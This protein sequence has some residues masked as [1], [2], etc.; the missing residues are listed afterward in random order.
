MIQW[1]WQDSREVYAES[2]A[3]TTSSL[4]MSVSRSFIW[5]RNVH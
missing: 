2:E 3:P 4:H 1:G 5:W